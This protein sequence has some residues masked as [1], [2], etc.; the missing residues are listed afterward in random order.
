MK[1]IPYPTNPVPRVCRHCD[2]LAGKYC[3]HYKTDLKTARQSFVNRLCYARRI[4]DL[5]AA[6]DNKYGR[7]K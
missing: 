2:S 6:T 7:A 1:P 5:A 4:D 3:K